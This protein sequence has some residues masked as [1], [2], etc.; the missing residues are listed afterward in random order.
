M[1]SDGKLISDVKIWISCSEQHAPK[2]N[3][4]EDD[5][6]DLFQKIIL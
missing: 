4:N 6:S 1:I 2:G 3:D 5:Y